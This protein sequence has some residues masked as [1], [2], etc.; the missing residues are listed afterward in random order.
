MNLKA[1]VVDYSRIGLY[2]NANTNYSFIVYVTC[3][4]G[5]NKNQAIVSISSIDECKYAVIIEERA[6]CP[7]DLSIIDTYVQMHKYIFSL[8]FIVFGV[9]LGIFGR[10][11]WSTMIFVLVAISICAL[12]FVRTCLCLTNLACFIPIRYTT[13]LSKIYILVSIHV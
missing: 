10:S 11:L 13:R 5:L 1:V 8:G 2:C 3:N 12:C 9:L 6:G 7:A 4:N